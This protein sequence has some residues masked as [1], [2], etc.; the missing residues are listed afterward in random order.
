MKKGIAGVLFLILLLPLSA[1][2]ADAVRL[3]LKWQHQFQ[4]AGYYAAQA[5]GYYQSAGLDVEIIPSQPGEDPV[6]R[7]LL[8]NAEF[9]IGATDL[10]LLREKGAPVV[11]LAVIF[12]HSPLALVTLRQSGLQSIH[13]MAGRR[14]M[15]ESGSSEIYAYLSRE[16]I[17]ADRFTLISHGF[18]VT[19]LISGNVDAMSVYVTDEPFELGRTGL[20]Y[21]LYSPRAVGIDF[22][23]DSLFT[24]ESQLKLQPERVKAFREA[25]LKGWEYAMQHPEELVQLIY[26]RYSQRHSIEHLRFEARQMAS[27]LQPSLIKIGYI[28]PDRWRHIAEVYASLGMMKPDFNFKGF[29]YDPNPPPPDLGWLYGSLAAA[30]SLVLAVTLIA[31]RFSRLSTTLKNTIKDYNQAQETLQESNCFLHAT[32]DALSGN[33]ALLDEHGTIL[34]VNKGWRDFAAKNDLSVET[35]NEGI[36]YLD[37]C[38]RAEGRNREEAIPFADGI[39]AVLAGAA[40]SFFLEYPCHSPD[41]ERWFRGCVTSFLS[42]GK[43]FVVVAHE[44]ITERNRAEDALRSSEHALQKKNAELIRFSEAVSHDLKSPLIT[45]LTF[46]NYLEKDIRSQDAAKAETDMGYIRSAAETMGRLLDELRDLSQIGLVTSNP[47]E[48]PLQ[49]IVREAL[50]LVAGRIAEKGVQVIVMEDPVILFGDRSR[51]VEVFQNLIDNA[52]KFT[53]DQ[54]APCIEI[55]AEKS[56]DEIVL[57]V[58]DNGIGIEPQHQEKIFGLFEKLD[59]RAEGTGMGL[60]LVKRIVEV[61]G[62]GIRVESKGP[63]LGVCFRFTLAGTK[64]C[65]PMISAS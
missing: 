60:A 17:S 3:Q 48:T 6:Q 20:A 24:T 19:D 54:A 26:S 28:N 25:S 5:Q 47:V 43:R 51:L 37:V 27:L 65:R 16:G 36:N 15:I 29:L 46:L 13:D 8:G 10:L 30:L 1:A 12:Q 57:F 55:G 63:G 62:G 14:I 50:V 45:I 39:R 52:V 44:N 59:P 49:E 64:L 56:G 53:G 35:V 42:A 18:D 4:F 61:H 32:I 34:L 22:Y 2:A 11:V 9:G 58:R 31:V 21:L 40:E 23:G 38:D 41:E 33:I 7:V